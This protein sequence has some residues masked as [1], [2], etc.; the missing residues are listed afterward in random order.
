M[1][2]SYIARLV[3]RSLMALNRA[4][5]WEMLC[6]F[7]LMECHVLWTWAIPCPLEMPHMERVFPRRNSA[8]HT[9]EIRCGATCGHTCKNEVVNEQYCI[10]TE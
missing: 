4:L 1:L 9:H 10:K 8:S 6:V 3:H 5:A 7:C 2:R